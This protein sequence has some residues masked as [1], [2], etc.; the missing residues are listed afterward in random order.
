MADIG[1]ILG[2]YNEEAA[3]V[4]VDSFSLAKEQ[5][6]DCFDVAHLFSTL[7]TNQQIRELFSGLS[8]NPQEIS[9]SAEGMLAKVPHNAT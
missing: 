6:R 2:K 8:Q 1:S 7:S 4:V 3:T 5:G 9:L